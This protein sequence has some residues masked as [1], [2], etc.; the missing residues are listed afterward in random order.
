[1]CD[2]KFECYVCLLKTRFSKIDARI[3]HVLLWRT[4]KENDIH[5][6]KTRHSLMAKIRTDA[7][8]SKQIT[9]TTKV[10]A[11][12]K[13]QPKVVEDFFLASSMI[14]VTIHTHTK[15]KMTT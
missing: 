6:S 9:A 8:D 7:S 14:P 4:R 3:K 1:M 2:K 13:K 15:P 11:F 5:V 10:E 12:S